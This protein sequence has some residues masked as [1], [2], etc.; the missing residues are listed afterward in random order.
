MF[1]MALASA[2]IVM[3]IPARS[4]ALTTEAD[5]FEDVLARTV[6]QAISRGQARGIR[7]EENTYQVYARIG[8]RWVPVRGEATTLP[9]GLTIGLVTPQRRAEDVRPQIVADASGIVSGP[10][11]RISKGSRFRDIPV[12][13][14]IRNGAYE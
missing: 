10:S 4:D 7:I 9:G 3:A 13:D 5:L 1:I 8:G 14:Q 2:M 12:Y 11:V 6:D